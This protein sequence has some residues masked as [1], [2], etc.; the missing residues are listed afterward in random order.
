[1]QLFRAS[2]PGEIA[3]SPRWEHG[4]GW[5]TIYMPNGYGGKTRAELSEEEHWRN[6]LE[7]K[8]LEAVKE[9]LTK[10]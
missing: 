3:E 5:D 2:H 10:K 8:P 4:Y 6:Y 9:F 7:I 1:L